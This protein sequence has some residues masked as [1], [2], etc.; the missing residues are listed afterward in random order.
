[1]GLLGMVVDSVVG[2]VRAIGVH[3]AIGLGL[4]LWMLPTAMLP[5]TKFALTTLLVALSYDGAVLS[6][7]EDFGPSDLALTSAL[8]FGALQV[9][10]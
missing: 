3:I 7:D 2:T 10:G 5:E 1:M 6:E 4:L 9:V 8:S